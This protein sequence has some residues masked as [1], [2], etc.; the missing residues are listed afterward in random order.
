MGYDGI[1]RNGCFICLEKK[2]KVIPAEFF[3]RELKEE[4]VASIMKKQQ[5][6][7]ST[8]VDQINNKI[9][10]HCHIE[11]AKPM[12]HIINLSIKQGKVP[13]LYKIARI[14]PLYKKGAA[15][16]CG[17]YRPVSLLSA[18]SKILEKAICRQIMTYFSVEKLLCPDQYGFRPGNQTTHVV[19]RMINFIA[20]KAYNNEVVLTTFIDLSKAFDCIQYDKLYKKLEYLGIT[21][22]E[23]EWFK[24]YLTGRQ[25][26][27]D[28]C[29]LYT[30]PSPRD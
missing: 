4:D 6:K 17:N 26:C 1:S 20:E 13:L 25:Q 23:L 19:H 3:F 24:N 14:I 27:V 11:L 30:S 21:G 29:L 28:I 2:K 7:L 22:I 8:G 5:P 12:T 10:K 18:L 16:E 15:N 9:V